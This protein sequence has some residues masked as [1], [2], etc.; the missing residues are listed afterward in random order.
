MLARKLKT[1]TP[2]IGSVCAIKFNRYF[3]WTVYFTNFLTEL[4]NRI[5][6][7]K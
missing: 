5:C 6:I 7:T 2:N 3:Y 4:E 1:A